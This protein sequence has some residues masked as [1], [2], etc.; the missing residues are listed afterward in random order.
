[1]FIGHFGIG[2]AAKKAAPQVSLGLLFIAVQFLDLLWPTL[3]LLDIEHVAIEP[4]ITKLTPLDF[5][6]YPITHSLLMV[7][8]WSVAFGVLYFLFRKNT[9]AALVLSV[10]VLSHWFLDLLVHRPDLPLYPG[11]SI[12]TGF[13]LW[14][15]PLA[16]IVIEAII[17]I[18]GIYFYLQTTVA[19]N[20]TGKIVFWVLSIFLAVIFILNIFGPPPPNVNA[21]AWAGQLQWIFVLLAFWA[22]R[23]RKTK[24]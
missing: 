15:Y 8:C 12:K 21:I 17:F 9:K 1:M 22:D 2:F 19:K 7:V 23:N 10:C 5:Y 14:N 16:E 20:K 13:G 18:I 3:L 11:Y 4:G 6:D 24:L